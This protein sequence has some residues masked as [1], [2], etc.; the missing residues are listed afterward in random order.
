M[1]NVYSVFGTRN[2][3][4]F[5]TRIPADDIVRPGDTFSFN[6]KNTLCEACELL[7]GKHFNYAY[8]VNYVTREDGNEYR[9]NVPF[10]MVMRGARGKLALLLKDCNTQLDFLIRILGKPI[11]C[12]G[13][14]KK[15][16]NEY[17]AR[18]IPIFDL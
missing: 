10:K 17:E 7:N 12:V 9:I 15:R 2:F 16:I 1:A 14:I 6:E 13:T 8:A 5:N 4:G 11:I 3:E 18:E